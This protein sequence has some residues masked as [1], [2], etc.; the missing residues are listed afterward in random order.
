MRNKNYY[1]ISMILLLFLCLPL[2]TY[3]QTK[4]ITGTVTSASDSQPLPGATVQIKGTST[5]ETTDFDGNY[6]IEANTGDILVFSFVGYTTQEATVGAENV[7]SVALAEDVNVLTEVVITGYG[8]Q[9][10][11]TLTTSISKLDTRILETSTRSNVGSALQGTVAGLRVTNTTGQPGSTPQI[12]LRG[13]TNFGND[14]PLILVDG[15]PSSFY[16]LNSDDIESI[17]V[18]KDAAATAIYGARSANGVI[19]VTTK[20]GKVGKSSVNY[21]F[22]YSSNKERDDQK[23][24][25]AED[26]INYNRQSIA[27]FR[28]VTNN[29]GAFGAFLN[30]NHSAAT[31]NNTT[32]D[33]FTTQLLTPDNQYLLNQPGWKSIPDILDPSQEILFFDNKDVGDRIYQESLSKD[34]YISFDGGNEKG[35]YYLGLGALDNDGL[36]LGSGF[37]RYSGKFS[38]SYNIKENFKVNSTILYTHSN[39]SRSPLGSDNTVFRR[40]QGQASTARTYDSNED[41]T[42]SD[43][44]AVGQNQGF[45]NP[46]YYQDKFIR[47]NLEQRLSATVG[48][49]WNILDDL[50]F[51]LTGSHFTINNHNENFNKAYRV[52][53]TTGPLRTARQASVDLNRTLRNQLTGTLNYI[54]KFG[55]HNVNVLIGAEYYKNNGF[56]SSA[57]TRN[58]PTDLIQ[59]LN[60]APEADGVP[61]SSESEYVITSTFGRLLYDFNDRYLVSLTYRYDG[62]SRLGNN[63]FGFFPGVS[64]GWN[65]HN[66]KFF[67]NSSLSNT[68]SKLKPR[69]SYGVNGNQDVLSNYGVFGSYGSRGVYN[70]Q[71]GYG[72][73]SLPTL[74]L[75]W[76][77]ATTLNFGLD[78]SL[79]NDRLSFIAD[80]YSRDIKD[81][82]ATLTLPFYTGFSGILTNNGTYRNKGFEL[83]IN[84]DVIK[85]DDLNWNVGAT[86][87]QNRNYVVKLPEND[88]DF[89]RQGGNLIWNSETG[90]D[91]WVGGLQEGKRYGGDLIVAFIQEDIYDTQAQAD[92]DNGITDELMP[93]FSRNQ[94]WAGDVKWKDVNNDGIINGS[95]REVIGRTTP[96][97]V[98]GLF[99]NLNYKRF[100]LFVKTDFATGH[101]V[102]NHIKN[103]GYGQTQGNLAQPIEVLDSWTP[104]NTDADLPRF[105]FVNGAKNVW[106]GSE[107]RGSLQAAGNNKFWEKGD[108]LA[109]RE[110][111]L[112]YDLP[113]NIFKDKIQNLS[114]YLT[115]TNLHYF[116]GFSG[117]SPE[118][119]GV[120]YGTFPVPKTYTVG[121]NLT[122]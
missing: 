14:A 16:G 57:G 26:H 46:L 81:K 49:E 75:K 42:F 114:V 17:E 31:G 120:Q 83:E 61:T 29:P 86:F 38:G 91:E 93:G 11:A 15:I 107:G 28:E 51:A 43:V 109:L 119:G 48:I 98:G 53:S 106:R 20:T 58:S 54:K 5:G 35:T 2:S 39:L 87:T 95:D 23:Y 68:I 90:Q 4:T 12:I 55:D 36:I 65:A 8:K 69:I 34:H 78:L 105:V 13:G 32:N 52:G 66:E 108:Y 103:K 22:R 80:V 79:F 118:E 72:N 104:T 9:T 117:D 27:W 3:G 10:R 73:T 97:F 100:N 59:T 113:T 64:F 6:S 74:D 56:F 25:G 7:I 85:T 60:A 94:R 82:L 37:K 71:T 111:T 92:A 110:V 101:L 40:F 24:I 21:K 33:P 76:E 45:G 67:E 63:K 62:S 77:K 121:L 122:F 99:T 19:L 1:I 96:D 18:L 41:G 112:S 70:G 88:N 44:Y 47:K 30:G 89:N 102:W 116:K 50:T 84:G 115:G